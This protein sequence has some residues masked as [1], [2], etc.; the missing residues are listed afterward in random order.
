MVNHEK[1]DILVVDDLPEK[2]LVYETILRGLGQNVV[3]ARSG[4]EALR[5]LLEREFAV[6][7]LD[8][9]MP[10]MDGFETAA[11]IRSR[12]QS[13]HTPII[14]VTAFSDEMHTAQGYSL[15]A[16]D[17]I[18]SPIVPEILRTKVGVFVDLYKKTQQVERQAEEHVALAQRKLSADG[19]GGKPSPGVPCRGEHRSGPLSRLRRHTQGAC[20][21]GDSRSRRTVRG[22]P[23]RR[24][25]PNEWRTDIAWIDRESG[26]RHTGLVTGDLPLAPLSSLIR[27]VMATGTGQVFAE[28]AQFLPAHENMTAPPHPRASVVPFPHFNPD[29][30]IVVPLR[31]RGRTLGTISLS[32]GDAR[33]R[34]GS[35]DLALVKDLAG[36]A[37]I[38]IDNARLYRD[39]QENNRRKNEFL[40]MLAH[41]LRNPLAPIRSAVDILKMLN[42]DNETLQWAERRDLAAG[43]TPGPTGRRP[44]RHLADHGRQDPAPDGAGRC[45]HCG[46]AS[47]RDQPAA[48][49]SA[50]TRANSQP[51]LRSALD[52]RRP[53]AARTGAWPTS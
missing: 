34:V 23:D 18:L 29:R 16:V 11:M 17:Y 45:F 14:F 31:A 28:I 44:A 48:D 41:E 38:V 39:V 8:V 10:D 32:Q 20:E 24:A 50:Q 21:P 15:G 30:A 5:S 37:A 13:A 2:L 52:Q 43:R 53:G 35:D 19:G 33:A 47:R 25:R 22:Y 42:L 4:R 1:V 7:L 12:R 3:T 46:G 40:A 36:R 26:S 6:I 9:N 51:S 27:Q 49:R